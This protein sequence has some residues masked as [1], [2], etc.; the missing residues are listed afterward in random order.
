MWIADLRHS[1]EEAKI[2][3]L[4][5]FFLKYL[6]FIR[7][8]FYNAMIVPCPVTV[9]NTSKSFA[10]DLITVTTIIDYCVFVLAISNDFIQNNALET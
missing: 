6:N 10:S 2:F 5:I 9:V 1:G 8:F 4:W 3:F 7:D